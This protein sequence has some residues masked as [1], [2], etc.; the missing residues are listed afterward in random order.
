MY[1]YTQH[2]QVCLEQKMSKSS[3]RLLKFLLWNNNN[4]KNALPPP[5]PAPPTLRG[6]GGGGAMN[7]HQISKSHTKIKEGSST[8]LSSWGLTCNNLTRLNLQSASSP[9]D[10]LTLAPDVKTFYQIV[11]LTCLVYP[12]VFSFVF[13]ILPKQRKRLVGP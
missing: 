5:P 2:I 10:V 7:G 11:P 1:V 13:K 8:W 6:R 12:K 4:K 9:A 3:K